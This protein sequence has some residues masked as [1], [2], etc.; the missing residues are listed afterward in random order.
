MSG[1]HKVP[2]GVFESAS[3]LYGVTIE[4]FFIL[5][6]ITAIVCLSS[7]LMGRYSLHF[8]FGGSVVV[9]TLYLVFK[10][11]NYYAKNTFEEYIKYYLFTKNKFPPRY[12]GRSKYPW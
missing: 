11:S 7:F 3:M 12:S 1:E 9:G 6:T 8:L 10:T 4:Q 2:K 5:I